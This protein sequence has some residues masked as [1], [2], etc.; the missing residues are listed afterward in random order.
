MKIISYYHSSCLHLIYSGHITPKSGENAIEQEAGFAL[1]LGIG[2][3]IGR[4]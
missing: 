1:E 3:T 2:L 4:F